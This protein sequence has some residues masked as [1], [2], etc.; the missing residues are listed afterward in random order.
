VSRGR[1]IVILTSHRML[2]FRVYKV[3]IF[4]K[5]Y[6]PHSKRAKNILLGKYSIIPAPYVV[7]LDEHPLGAKI[8]AKLGDTTGRRTVPNVLINGKSIGGGDD[9]ADLD[10]RMALI[11]K[12]KTIGG[13]QIQEVKERHI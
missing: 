2:I 8:Q 5:T 6:C 7:E 1:A 12:I 9:I 13:K 3:I 10:S 11:D 4:S